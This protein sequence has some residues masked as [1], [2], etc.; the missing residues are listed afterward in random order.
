MMLDQVRFNGK[1]VTKDEHQEKGF[2][3]IFRLMIGLMMLPD[4]FIFTFCPI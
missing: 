1:Q 2:G 3:Y 4:H